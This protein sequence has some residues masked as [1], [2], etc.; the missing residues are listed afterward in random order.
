MKEIKISNYQNCPKLA[1][2]CTIC[3]KG[4]NMGLFDSSTPS[5]ATIRWEK[6]SSER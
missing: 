3:E 1:L 6:W 2:K 5:K 4:S